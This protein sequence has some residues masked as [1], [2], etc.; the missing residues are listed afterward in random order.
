[1]DLSGSGGG[2]VIAC[3]LNFKRFGQNVGARGSVCTITEKIW[4]IHIG[5]DIDNW[6][7]EMEKK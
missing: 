3:A 2:S 7:K 5:R 4:P 6:T 1:M